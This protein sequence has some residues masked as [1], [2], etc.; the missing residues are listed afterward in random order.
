[1]PQGLCAAI[2]A[3]SLHA[4]ISDTHDPSDQEAEIASLAHQL[5][6]ADRLDSF[7]RRN[8]K[9]FAGT[10]LII[11]VVDGSSLDCQAT[12][13]AALLRCVKASRATLLHIHLHKF[14]PQGVS[15]VAVLAESH[16][17]VHTWP[18]VGFG[19]FDAFMCGEADP[20]ACVEILREA[21]SAGDVRVTEFLRGEGIVS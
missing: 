20:W 2:K 15:G 19:A 5:V 11:E 14:S 7:S 9:A 10:H 16:I 17:S 21:F 13:E 12:V 6:D 4:Q 3:A 8:G 1:M 18:E